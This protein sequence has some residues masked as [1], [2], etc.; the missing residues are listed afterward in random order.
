VAL[1]KT[2]QRPSQTTT[3]FQ[4]A[5]TGGEVLY[6]TPSTIKRVLLRRRVKQGLSAFLSEVRGSAEVATGA[7]QFSKK[8]RQRMSKVSVLVVS[9]D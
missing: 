6:E 3:S 1:A 2:L 8:T 5:V 9:Q 4:L 7:T